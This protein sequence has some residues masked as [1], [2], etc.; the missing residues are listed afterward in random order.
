MSSATQLMKP[1]KVY[2][3]FPALK[4]VTDNS[5]L[6]SL[7]SCVSRRNNNNLS[8]PNYGSGVDSNRSNSYSPVPTENDA[9]RTAFNQHSIDEI[10]GNTRNQGHISGKSKCFKKIF[11]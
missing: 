5:T 11:T 4:V 1:E 3:S 9:G 10:L 7:S 8:T 6:S 2:R